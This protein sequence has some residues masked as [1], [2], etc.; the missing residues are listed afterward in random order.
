MGR[1]RVCLFKLSHL[2][3]KAAAKPAPERE[4]ERCK[5]ISGCPP[6]SEGYTDPTE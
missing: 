3:C 2:C 6:L 4:N 5:N 1:P